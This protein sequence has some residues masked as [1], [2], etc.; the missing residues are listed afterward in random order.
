MAYFPETPAQCLAHFVNQLESKG[1]EKGSSLNQLYLIIQKDQGLA[2]DY[3]DLQSRVRQ[4]RK[5]CPREEELSRKVLLLLHE[6]ELQKLASIANS[7][8]RSEIRETIAQLYQNGLFFLLGEFFNLLPHALAQ[9]QLSLPIVKK[10][11]PLFIELLTNKELA[12]PSLAQRF[13]ERYNSEQLKSLLLQNFLFQGD[14]FKITPLMK[15]L[16]DNNLESAKWIS[17]LI[18]PQ[19]T[20][21]QLIQSV[22]IDQLKFTPLT[23]ILDVGSKDVISWV[24]ETLSNDEYLNQLHLTL[25]IAEN[26]DLD[27]LSLKISKK[28]RDWS[29]T[30]AE[31]T[32]LNKIE[33]DQRDTFTTFLQNTKEVKLTSDVG[34]LIALYALADPTGAAIPL[35]IDRLPLDCTPEDLRELIKKIAS[36]AINGD[37]TLKSV[38][39]ELQK[40][41]WEVVTHIPALEN[42]T[43]ALN[44]TK[45]SF[46]KLVIKRWLNGVPADERSTARGIINYICRSPKSIYITNINS[47]VEPIPW[48]LI[49]TR[50]IQFSGSEIKAIPDNFRE[51]QNLVDLEIHESAI[52]KIKVGDLPDH[53]KNIRLNAAVEGLDALP[54]VE[55]LRMHYTKS[56]SELDLNH[57]SSITRPAS[58]VIFE[59]EKDAHI[60]EEISKGS[61]FIDKIEGIIDETQP[62]N[63]PSTISTMHLIS[64]PER[65][66]LHNLLLYGMISQA[67]NIPPVG[68]LTSL[69]ADEVQRVYALLDIYK[70]NPSKLKEFLI[71]REPRLANEFE[72]KFQQ[73]EY[74]RQ[75][76]AAPDARQEKPIDLY[77]EL[78]NLPG[79]ARF[80]DKSV[81]KELVVKLKD[82]FQ[83]QLSKGLR[84]Q[85]SYG[86]DDQ[87]KGKMRYEIYLSVTSEFSR[88]FF[89]AF[90]L[91]FLASPTE[92]E[93]WQ[94]EVMEELAD[95][96]C[97]AQ[98]FAQ[99]SASKRAELRE[100]FAAGKLW[101]DE[102]G[103][104]E[105]ANSD[106]IL[107]MT[108]WYPK[109]NGS[110]PIV[111]K[112]ISSPI[113]MWIISLT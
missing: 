49:D 6:K 103:T 113:Q 81:K 93:K 22:E 83:Q 53:I 74:L 39:R 86:Q 52:K 96:F 1:G 56:N 47:S 94:C 16:F 71:Q 14:H 13:Y 28:L 42:Q 65:L 89:Q 11:P 82:L 48:F 21:S 63:L 85:I 101:I 107:F 24:E 69:N 72:R 46:R 61:H 36:S 43:K 112:K 15:A 111:S 97:N 87:I 30:T 7:E 109:V 8:D 37:G 88:S 60:P 10:G 78:F 76:I 41:L 51:V 66:Q 91:G 9:E 98:E 62:A 67:E 95:L 25:K 19:T 3:Q 18:G 80:L 108:A 26:N 106:T 57:L 20:N 70:D 90:T 23:I 105:F 27:T 44:H 29:L 17:D 4:L 79:Y 100:A 64:I 92:G 38:D 50:T 73:L 33:F 54:Q 84:M 110:F 99:L 68:K 34:K 31:R 77:V 35:L 5:M 58:Q 55:T 45:E 2:S 12:N 40:K 32:L 75:W 59:I 104:N 102:K